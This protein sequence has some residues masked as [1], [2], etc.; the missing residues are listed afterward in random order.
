M[1]A[2]EDV[3]VSRRRR[4]KT[5][6]Q[7]VRHRPEGPAH[8][9]R[10]NKSLV[11]IGFPFTMP[12]ATLVVPNIVVVIAVPIAGALAI[13]VVKSVVIVMIHIMMIAIIMILGSQQR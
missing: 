12:V 1:V 11:N 2:D 6:V 10:E 13:V 7:V 9:G 8:F 3:A 5:H 4:S